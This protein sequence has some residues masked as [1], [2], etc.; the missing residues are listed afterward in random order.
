MTYSAE[1]WSLE[2]EPVGRDGYIFYHEDS[3]ELPLYW[4]YGG[5]DVVLIVRVDAPT[6]LAIRWPWV[7][8]RERRILE[9][10][11]RELIRKKAPTCS[12]DIDEKNLC[13]YLRE[14]KKRQPRLTLM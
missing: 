12:A 3:R 13:V 10:V 14:K 7:V 8:G 11:A 1:N 6:K 5:G 4:E 9:R 2:C